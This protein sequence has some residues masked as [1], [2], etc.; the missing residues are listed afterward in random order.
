MINR[1][2]E[3]ADTEGLEA[4][5]VRRLAQ[6]FGVTPMA[7]YWHFSN[8]DELL[9][10]LGDFL[11]AS[12]DV[13]V[14]AGASWDRQLECIVG[15]MVAAFRSHPPIAEL[16]AHRILMAP[17]GID[18]TERALALLREVG[19][20]VEMSATLAG[21]ALMTALM[22]VTAEP[23]AENQVSAAEKEIRQGEKMAKV[24]QLDPAR[25][26]NV[27]ASFSS[28]M[29]C[30]DEDLYYDTGVELFVAGVRGLRERMVR[31]GSITA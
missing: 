5:T 22:L 26:P 13:R 20:D 2:V 30:A 10:A 12:V 19:F 1:A 23:G 6:E 29:V 11:L 7:L 15:A 17:E 14:E 27:I 4:V 3:L 8:K 9:D 16:A 28:F 21:H 31:A 24:A 18:L 25:Y